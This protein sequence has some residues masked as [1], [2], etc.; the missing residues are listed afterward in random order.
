MIDAYFDI[1]A[2][3]KHSVAWSVE[4]SRAELIT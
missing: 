4:G 3:T 1:S 2:A